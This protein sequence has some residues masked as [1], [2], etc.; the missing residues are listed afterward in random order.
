MLNLENAI[1]SVHWLNKHLNNPK[2]VLLNASIPKVTDDTHTQENN[3]I[4]NSIFFD[5]KNKFSDIK[6]PF[7]N[8]FPSEQQFQNE[9]RQLGINKDS[10]IIVYDD[11]GLYSS[12][13]AWWMFKAFNHKNVAV[14]DGGLPAWLEAGYEVENEKK[15]IIDSGDFV[16]KYQPKLMKFFKDVK[17][18]TSN[19][20]HKIIDARSEARFKGIVA[21]PRKG[22]RSGKIPNSINLPFENILNGYTLKDKND[23]NT[24][25]NSIL[26][27]EDQITFSCGSGI[28]ACVLALGAEIAGFKNLSVYDGS[29]T[30]WGSLIPK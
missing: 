22:L 9:A 24:I 28:T 19:P 8:T 29:W 25:F 16:A 5:L 2:L 14:L 12:P 6:A 11:K 20:S 1:V 30:E 3:Q 27:K 18:E 4:P 21:E 23:L 10:I 15:Y 13:R 26:N 17:K 7:P